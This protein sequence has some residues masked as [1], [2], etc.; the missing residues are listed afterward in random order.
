MVAIAPGARLRERCSPERR[1]IG[2]SARRSA[3]HFNASGRPLCRIYRPAR[4]VT[5]AGLRTTR[6]WILEIEPGRKPWIE[7]LMGWTAS[8][9]PYAQI[10]MRFPSLEAAERHAQRLGLDYRVRQPGPKRRR[11]KNYM[12]TIAGCTSRKVR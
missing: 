9:D 8:D 2:K 11:P 10:R 6:D 4:T 1:T 5:Q 3:V 12:N 7:P